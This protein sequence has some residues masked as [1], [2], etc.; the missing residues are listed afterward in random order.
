[1]EKNPSP[2]FFSTRGRGVGGA[3]GFPLIGRKLGVA[4]GGA[5]SA[6]CP[7]DCQLLPVAGASNPVSLVPSDF[8]SGCFDLLDTGGYLL[9][10][11]SICKSTRAR[12]RIVKEDVFVVG[13]FHFHVFGDGGGK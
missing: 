10:Q 3:S 7:H 5:T 1:M 8:L 11:L 2:G 4:G 13:L 9:P 6:D 12:W